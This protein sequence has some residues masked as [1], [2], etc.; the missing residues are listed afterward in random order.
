VLAPV[1][2]A[3]AVGMAMADATEGGA[4]E[5]ELGAVLGVRGGAAAVGAAVRVDGG[6][7]RAAGGATVVVANS[8]WVGGRVRDAF[9]AEVASGF[10]ADV[11]ALAGGADA[12]NR[13]VGAAT[14]GAIARVVDDVAPDTVALLVSAVFFRGAWTHAFRPDET[15]DRAFRA[16]RGD[17]TVR[18]MMRRHARRRYGV[19]DLGAGR[20]ALRLLELPYGADGRFAAVFGLPAGGATLDD[21]AARVGDEWPAWMGAVGAAPAV[22]SLLGVPRFR[23]EFG[24]ASVKAALTA[25]GVGAAW[26]AGAPGGGPLFGRLSD[27]PAVHLSDVVHKAV[28]EVTEEGTTAAAASAAVVMSRSISRD[29]P[30]SV[31]VDA[32]FLFAIRD[33]VTGLLLFVGRV[34]N[35]AAP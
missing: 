28:V 33:T 24:A 2:V 15:V 22:I 3:A 10:G 17:V 30:L 11:R 21:V 31:V 19:A 1:S 20:G 8:V 23:A 12:V 13:W 16:P 14:G 26:G 9:A 25:L 6:G 7:G 32:P 29:D 27:D 35:P 18:M 4:V 34:D 5:A